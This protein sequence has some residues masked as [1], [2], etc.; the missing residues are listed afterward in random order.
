[1]KPRH[2]RRAPAEKKG[3]PKLSELIPELLRLDE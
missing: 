1:M 2:P 3:A